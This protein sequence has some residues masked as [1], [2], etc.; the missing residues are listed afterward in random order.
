MHQDIRHP[1]ELFTNGKTHLGCDFVGLLN[2]HSR[3]DLNVKIDVILQSR[4]AR[5]TLFNRAYPRI[6]CCHPANLFK[7]LRWR[8]GICETVGRILGNAQSGDDND[9]TDGKSTIV[10][11]C[12]ESCWIE[13]GK[14]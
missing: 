8:H 5:I 1:I 4:V 7:H 12:Q 10:I 13:N 6:G 11:R 9:Q 14:R 2:A 3:I